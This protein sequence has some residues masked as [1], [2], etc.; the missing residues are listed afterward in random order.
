LP[1][2]IRR[3]RHGLPWI[4]S[5]TDKEIQHLR[6]H[7][8]HTNLATGYALEDDDVVT[9]MF[10]SIDGTLEEHG[11]FWHLRNPDGEVNSGPDAAAVLCPA[12]GANPL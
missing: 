6:I 4:T 11:L 9:F 7:V 8:V 10:D 3:V 1:D 12:L 2:D 5:F